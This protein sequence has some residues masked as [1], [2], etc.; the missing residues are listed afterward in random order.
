[1]ISPDYRKYQHILWRASPY[2]ELIEY[3]LHTVTYG[4]NCAPFLALRVLQSIASNECDDNE[5][6]R[7]ALIY[8]TYVDDICDGA[9][10]ISDAL[11]LQNNLI[12]ILSR[13]GFELK[14]WASNTP[15]ILDAV[16]TSDRVDKPTPFDDVESVGTKVLGLEWHQ[17]GDFF[18]C[19]LNLELS[20]VFSKRSI[21]SLVA[22]IFDPLGLFGPS[23]FLAKTVMQRTWQRELSWDDPLPIDIH[24][25]WAAFVS[26]L[27]ALGRIQVPRH[28]NSVR[29]SSC[30]LL[31]FCDASLHGYAA[32]VYI[33]IVDPSVDNPSQTVF[34]IGTKTKL[35]PLKPLTVPRLELNAASQ[36]R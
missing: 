36:N 34:L 18:C 33:R 32:V 10:S 31:G 1:M 14:K 17:D 15:T 22:R 9:D 30:Y 8:Q 29:G 11:T 2:D 16:P 20:P 3:E 6:V 28:I 7:S 25:E 35:A 5:P 24:D 19:A 26:D 12:S 21:L 4:V 23:V 27:P 13:S